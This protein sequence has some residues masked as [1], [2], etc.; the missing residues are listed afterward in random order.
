MTGTA[1]DIADITAVILAGGR[2]TRMGGTDKGLVTLNNRAM[3]E[4]VIETLRPQAG[5][6]LINANRNLDIYRRYGCPVISDDLEGYHGPLAGIAS[7]MRAAGTDLLLVT[8][9]DS[10]FLPDDLV[11]R[12]FDQMLENHA[13]ISVAHN[14]KRMQPVFALINTGLRDSLRDY[15]DKGGRKIDLWYNQHTMVSVDFADKPETFLNINTPEDILEIESRLDTC[16]C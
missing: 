9:C 11:R 2:A 4:Y 15:L 8:P 16:K 10:P 12:L 5:T 3:I 13:D 1:M 7:A 6:L 14:G